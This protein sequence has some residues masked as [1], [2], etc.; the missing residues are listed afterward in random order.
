MQRP[1]GVLKDEFQT[2][3]KEGKLQIHLHILWLEGCEFTSVPVRYIGEHCSPFCILD[4][5]IWNDLISKTQPD[6]IASSVERPVI[7]KN[8]AWKSVT[9]G[10]KKQQEWLTI[11]END[12]KFMCW[13]V[14]G[15]CQ[16]QEGL[17]TICWNYLN[18][19]AIYQVECNEQKH[20]LTTFCPPFDTISVLCRYVVS[21]ALRDRPVWHLGLVRHSDGWLRGLW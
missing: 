9:G 13:W 2:A 7:F 5:D 8:P 17:E 12:G 20:Y 16:L 14:A 4:N 15:L 11:V 3:L 6:F 21:A 1:C 10:F 19:Q 18:L